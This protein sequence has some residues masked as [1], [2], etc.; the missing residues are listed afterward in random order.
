ME[1]SKNLIRAGIVITAVNF[2]LVA[3]RMITGFDTIP[4]TSVLMLVFAMTH[5]TKRYGF[6]RLV[7]FMLLTFVISWAYETL[8][9]LTGFPFGNYH[10]S[11]VL[12]AKIWLVPWTIM[13][14][15]FAMGY[16]S[17]SIASI[18][19][20]KT[21]NTIKGSEVIIKPLLASFIMVFWDICFDPDS[22]NLVGMWE[23]HD[24]G[25]YFGVPFSNYM[26]WFLCVFTFMFIFSLILRNS[27]E[28]NNN[29]VAIHSKAFWILN[30]AMYLQYTFT[31][32]YNGIYG[33][34]VEFTANNGHIYWTGD[35]Y[36]TLMLMTIFTMVFVSFYAVVR[37][38]RWKN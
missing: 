8:S 36:G 38:V 28:I 35:I 31:Y 5:G 7:Y 12:G 29:P 32:F 4:L 33:E 21:D 2:L 1:I 14:A 17:W 22:S 3:I 16:F 27:K 20:D 9:I 24:G 11:D 37:V 25:V 10:Y 23:W 6:K 26:G 15:Y 30:I 19:L 18:L 13:P 34:N